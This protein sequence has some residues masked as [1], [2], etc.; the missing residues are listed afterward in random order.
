[1]VTPKGDIVVAQADSSSWDKH[2]QKAATTIG[3]GVSSAG[4][5]MDWYDSIPVSDH[6][7][8]PTCNNLLREAT[9]APCCGTSFCDECIRSFMME[10]DFA[11][12]ECQ[13]HIPNG[14][15]GLI[16][17]VDVREFVDNYVR[18]YAHN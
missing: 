7:R 8:C 6:L 3:L 9:I 5:L 12:F 13:S 2:V 16:A 4:D 1:M 11:C 14:L 15:D 10:N 18:K 17:N